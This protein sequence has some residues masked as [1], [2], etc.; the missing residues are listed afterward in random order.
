MADLESIAGFSRTMFETLLAMDRDATTVRDG[1]PTGL[2]WYGRHAR[3]DQK[4][5]QTEP[6][7]SKELARRLCAEGIEAAAEVAYPRLDRSRRNRCDLVVSLADGS[8]LWI[9]IKG[10]WKEYWRQQGGM[11]FYE[12]YLLH[13]LV[14]GLDKSKTHTVPLDLEK[15]ASLRPDDADYVGMLLIGFDAAGAPMEQDVAKLENLAGLRHEPWRIE[16]T[17]WPD[18]HRG[19]QHVRCWFWYR[20]VAP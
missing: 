17:D 9:E 11:W 3:P 2:Y 1:E 15:L 8:T 13:P 14:G 20:A 19:G 4:R 6:N 18:P 7:W 12:S 16:S 10:A 5:P